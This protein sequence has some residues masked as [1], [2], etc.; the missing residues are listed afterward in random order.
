METHF[1][2]DLMDF[3]EFGHSTRASMVQVRLNTFLL[4]VG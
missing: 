3:F 2:G 1:K 4:Q